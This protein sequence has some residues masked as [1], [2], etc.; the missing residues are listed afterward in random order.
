MVFIVMTIF[1]IFPSGVFWL[2]EMV[3]GR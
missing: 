3:Y 1:Y 2:P